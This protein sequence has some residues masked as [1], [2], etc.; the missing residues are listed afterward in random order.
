[1]PLHKTPQELAD[2]LETAAVLRQHPL[3]MVAA[4]M[5]R[6]LAAKIEERGLE[7]P[8]VPEARPV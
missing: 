3:L 5:I 4:E 6:A 1:M 8:E 2:T 7:M